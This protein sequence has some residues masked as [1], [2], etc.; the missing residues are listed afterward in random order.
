MPSTV[1]LFIDVQ[2]A[3]KDFTSTADY[4][5]IIASANIWSWLGVLPTLLQACKTGWS[6]AFQCAIVHHDACSATQCLA[7]VLLESGTGLDDGGGEPHRLICWLCCTSFRLPLIIVVIIMIIYILWWYIMM[8]KLFWHVGKL[9]WQVGKL[10][11]QVW[12]LF[13]Q[14][15][16][17]FW[18]VE[19]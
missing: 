14:V 8:R 15:G 7:W 11:W 10:F 5:R 17:L 1:W 13:W 16:K 12:K 6:S 18:Q 19:K 4:P 3:S 9:V 2:L